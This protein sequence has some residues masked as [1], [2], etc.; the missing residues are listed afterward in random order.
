ML[1]K[2]PGIFPDFDF[3]RALSDGGSA[4]ADRRLGRTATWDDNRA[5]MAKDRTGFPIVAHFPAFLNKEA[6][7]GVVFLCFVY[8]Y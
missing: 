5:R 4:L 6:L 3:A 2:S 1:T 8:K 7:V